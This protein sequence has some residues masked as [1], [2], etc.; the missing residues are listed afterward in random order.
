ME[1]A[2]AETEWLVDVAALRDGNVWRL[3]CKV[4]VVQLCVKLWHSYNNISWKSLGNFMLPVE[5]NIERNVSEKRIV[6]LN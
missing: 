1:S 2:G 3:A 6:D 5:W 4:I